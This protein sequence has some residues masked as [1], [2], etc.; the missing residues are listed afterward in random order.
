M[1]VSIQGFN[2]IGIFM[3]NWDPLDEEGGAVCTANRDCEDA[4]K[5]AH[6]LQI[7]FHEVL[8]KMSNTCYRV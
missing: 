6:Q 5:I 3:H 2:V 4:R 7:P 1:T 8:I